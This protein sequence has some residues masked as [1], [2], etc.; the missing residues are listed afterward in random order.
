MPALLFS[1]HLC[2]PECWL[3]TD[4]WYDINQA[5]S[6]SALCCNWVHHGLTP[7]VFTGPFYCHSLIQFAGFSLAEIQFAL[8]HCYPLRWWL[9]NETFTSS[10]P[11]I[12]LMGQW[13]W[14]RRNFPPYILFQDSNIAQVFAMSHCP[15][16]TWSPRLTLPWPGDHP[17]DHD[18]DNLRE[19]LKLLTYFRFQNRE[20][21]KSKVPG[22]T[23]LSER[24][25]DAVISQKNRQKYSKQKLCLVRCL[26]FFHGAGDIWD[27]W[28]SSD[29][30]L[31]RVSSPSQRHEMG[32]CNAESAYCPLLILTV[33][34]KRTA[35]VTHI[36]RMLSWCWRN[37]WKSLTS[38][39]NH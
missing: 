11:F 37:N 10:P 13:C 12:W 39:K 36:K 4:N 34:L 33:T 18:P 20:F 3:S 28:I 2:L 38:P 17:H 29:C 21:H 19:C 22:A 7:W 15:P 27:I 32:K 9:A 25:N 14:L 8:A 24:Y 16:L 23:E 31:S 1:P 35:Y 26:R 5:A 30:H 6:C